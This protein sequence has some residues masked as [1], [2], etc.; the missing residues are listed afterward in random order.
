MADLTNSLEF[1]RILLSKNGT[2]R[3]GLNPFHE[4]WNLPSP[5]SSSITI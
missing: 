5:N 3:L 1:H 2:L 4:D